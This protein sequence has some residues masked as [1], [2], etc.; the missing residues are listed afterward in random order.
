MDTAAD[1][2][3][4]SFAGGSW[5]D[6]TSTIQSWQ[7]TSRKRLF[8]RRVSERRRLWGVRA[9]LVGR[10]STGLSTLLSHPPPSPPPPAFCPL[11][12]AEFDRIAGWML[13]V[14]I[15]ASPLMPQRGTRQFRPPRVAPAEPGHELA[16]QFQR[17]V[18][19]REDAAAAPEQ[20]RQIADERHH[21]GGG[22]RSVHVLKGHAAEVVTNVARYAVAI[23]LFTARNSWTILHL[24][25]VSKAL[26]VLCLAELNA[27]NMY[28]CARHADAP[29]HVA[30]APSPPPAVRPEIDHEAAA[31]RLAQYDCML[32]DVFKATL[33]CL[34]ALLVALLPFIYTPSSTTPPS[35]GAVAPKKK[36]KP[37]EAH[38]A[39][40]A[41][42]RKAITLRRAT[43]S[44]KKRLTTV[45]LVQRRPSLRRPPSLRRRSD[46]RPRTA[47]APES[48]ECV[49]A[50]MGWVVALMEHTMVFGHRIGGAQGVWNAGLL[51][52]LGLIHTFHGQQRLALACLSQ[53]S[54]LVDPIVGDDPVGPKR[55][56]GLYAASQILRGSL[57]RGS[58][59]SCTADDNDN[60]GGPDWRPPVVGDAHMS[61]DQLHP[62][63]AFLLLIQAKFLL[64][65]HRAYE[66]V[67]EKCTEWSRRHERSM[68]SAVAAV[69]TNRGDLDGLLLGRVRHVL[70]LGY[71]GRARTE[72]LPRSDAWTAMVRT[73]ESH[74][75]AAAQLTQLCWKIEYHWALSLCELQQYTEAIDHCTTSIVLYPG[76]PGAW[77]LLAALTSLV[78]HHQGGAGPPR[79]VGGG[80]AVRASQAVLVLE[81][82]RLECPESA[83]LQFALLCTMLRRLAHHDLH[84]YFMIHQRRTRPSSR[85]HHL[86]RPLP[87]LHRL[88]RD[89]GD[90]FPY[91]DQTLGLVKDEEDEDGV[92]STSGRTRRRHL[93]EEIVGL[94]DTLLRT[95]VGGMEEEEDEIVEE[96]EICSTST[97][98]LGV[99]KRR[100]DRLSDEELMTVLRFLPFPQKKPDACALTGYALGHAIQDELHHPPSAAQCQ[101][102]P[103]CGGGGSPA[104]VE[105][106]LRL[107]GVL[108]AIAELLCDAG[109]LTLAEEVLRRAH[110]ILTLRTASSSRP[111]SI[112]QDWIAYEGVRIYHAFCDTMQAAAAPASDATAHGSGGGNPV[113]AKQ[114]A[115]DVFGTLL[116]KLLKFMLLAPF[117]KAAFQMQ[118]AICLVL[119]DAMSALAA[120]RQSLTIDASDSRS[121]LLLAEAYLAIESP[122]EAFEAAQQALAADAH[123]TPIDVLSLPVYLF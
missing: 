39:A 98:F 27:M 49:V 5:D 73:A 84:H 83:S 48:P 99:L 120:V 2:H 59:S 20:E 16:V 92:T 37:T 104:F 6:A 25:D 23:S 87:F 30:L 55:C 9:P 4:Q 81:R 47:V 11:D 53:V 123:W 44:R 24:L 76:Y 54:H 41:L 107:S 93:P 26:N 31:H 43:T 111:S 119:G 3:Q 96:E 77:I 88:R 60:G 17:F 32:S 113:V 19:L 112:Q 21:R 75:S 61:I 105:D 85:C 64:N 50:G 42:L 36:R 95:I 8:G 106:D 115:N 52:R 108:L 56:R 63:Y 51:L 102:G 97:G 72:M 15:T 34:D 94:F 86:R 35:S 69:E 109:Y 78:N 1:E 117:H 101:Q 114:D 121:L 45:K 66:E 82:G 65:D 103:Y 122:V 71:L 46:P 74:L 18:P 58:S 7:R 14:L 10:R 22:S 29:F 79:F 118:A 13:S 57:D 91:E 40:A 28:A 89:L 90:V 12:V 110:R 80:R 38:A 68:A 62:S 70:G 100:L 33:F 67:V 116:A